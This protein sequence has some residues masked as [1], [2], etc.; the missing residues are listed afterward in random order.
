VVVR[1]ANDGAGSEKWDD[2]AVQFLGLMLDA[3]K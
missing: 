3:I 1:L 2:Y